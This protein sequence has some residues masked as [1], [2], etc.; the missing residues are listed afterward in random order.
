MERVPGF[1]SY[2]TV[3]FDNLTVDGDVNGQVFPDERFISVSSDDGAAAH[4][5]MARMTQDVVAFSKLNVTQKLNDLRVD[6]DGR[7]DS[8]LLHKSGNA[9]QVLCRRVMQFAE[10]GLLR[11]L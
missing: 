10:N 11:L 1:H 5:K 8:A 3:Q 2:A 9:T 6:A 4:L 7:L